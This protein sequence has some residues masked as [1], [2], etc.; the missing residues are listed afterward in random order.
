MSKGGA[1]S[2]SG[3]KGWRGERSEEWDKVFQAE[4][5]PSTSFHVGKCDGAASDPRELGNTSF[6]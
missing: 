1:W 5:D 2:A 4:K 6:S 3:K